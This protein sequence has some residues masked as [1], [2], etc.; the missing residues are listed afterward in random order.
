[1]TFVNYY[2]SVVFYLICVRRAS[3]ET[4]QNEAFGPF[5]TKVHS[6]LEIHSKRRTHFK[7]GDDVAR[8]H[9]LLRQRANRLSSNQT[10]GIFFTPAVLPAASRFPPSALP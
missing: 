1:M 5:K 4:H 6:A 3:A 10:K 9:R 8:I 2:P 7:V